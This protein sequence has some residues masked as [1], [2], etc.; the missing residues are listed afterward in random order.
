MNS[1]RKICFF[2]ALVLI[3]FPFLHCSKKITDTEKP[4][5]SI[6]FP[7]NM[8]IVA[9]S[10]DVK[11]NASDNAGIK[12]VELLINGK[13]ISRVEK[14]PFQFRIYA[15]QY[16]NNSQIKVQVLACDSH[17]NGQYSESI[18]LRIDLD[19]KAQVIFLKE[20][21]FRGNDLFIS[22]M[23]GKNQRQLTHDFDV[24]M[25]ARF[26]SD[27]EKIT[28]GN[29]H[30][31][32]IIDNIHMFDSMV[33]IRSW[34]M[35]NNFTSSD[36][37]MN[38]AISL[39]YFVLSRDIHNWTLCTLDPERGTLNDINTPGMQG[40]PITFEI[41]PDGTRIAYIRKYYGLHVMD[42]DGKNY[43]KIQDGWCWGPIQFSPDGSKIVYSC[44]D[45]G[46]IYLTNSD[47]SN[48]IALTENDAYHPTFSPDATQVLFIDETNGSICVVSCDG[49]DQHTIYS[50]ESGLAEYPQFTDDGSKV[51]FALRE[52]YHDSTN[53]ADQGIYIINIDGIGLKK[54]ADNA[55]Y[56][57]L[58]PYAR[59]LQY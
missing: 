51:V 53:D 18:T 5:V 22:D 24:D 55:H 32:Y 16:E 13:P 50:P 56:P 21:S 29:S 26:S 11:C 33:N 15:A 42:W 4:V 3:L 10:V 41:S 8:S 36:P 40:E 9:D 38:S 46:K 28:C 49:T 6:T 7:Q 17:G 37:V 57:Q 30:K 59:L 14:E 45:H 54:L 19:K 20:R 2:F 39:V 44:G 47:G 43:K 52:N 27:G 35:P 25:M 34:P 1:K 58:K 31:V 23:D 48:N 12:W